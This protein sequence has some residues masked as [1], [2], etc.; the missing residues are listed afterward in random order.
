MVG[1][2]SFG[3]GLLGWLGGIK[4]RMLHRMAI[5]FRDPRKG[6]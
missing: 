2:C 6:V 5:N 4:R 1:R 3:V